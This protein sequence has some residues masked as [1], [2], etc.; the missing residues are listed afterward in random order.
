MVIILKWND[1]KFSFFIKFT[2]HIFIAIWNSFGIYCGICLIKCRIFFLFNI[3]NTDHSISSDWTCAQFI[4]KELFSKTNRWTT[5]MLSFFTSCLTNLSW[6]NLSKHKLVDRHYYPHCYRI[7]HST[8]TH[9][10]CKV[11]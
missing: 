2:W 5:E 4:R 7:Y 10:K 6:W 9:K 3:K 1:L 8:K 11:V